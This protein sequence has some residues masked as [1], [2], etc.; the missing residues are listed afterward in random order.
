MLDSMLGVRERSEKRGLRPRTG[1][2]AM[3]EFVDIRGLVLFSRPFPTPTPTHL[4]LLPNIA[5]SFFLY[6]PLSSFLL[7]DSASAR[8]FNTSCESLSRV[9]MCVRAQSGSRYSLEVCSWSLWLLMG[10]DGNRSGVCVGE[11]DAV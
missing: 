6:L 10:G 5:H 1:R 7:S 3:F 4:L 11:L 8:C 2:L 9:N